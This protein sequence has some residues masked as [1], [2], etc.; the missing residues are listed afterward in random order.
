MKE[1]LD[2]LTRITPRQFILATMIIC[3]L[4]LQ[5]FFF[6]K[7]IIQPKKRN[8][9]IITKSP[10]RLIARWDKSD[11]ENKIKGDTTGDIIR[12]LDTIHK[13]EYVNY[14][15]NDSLTV[16]LGVTDAK[17]DTS[18]SHLKEETSIKAS[19]PALPGGQ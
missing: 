8:F 15:F 7:A 19:I 17:T 13:E 16:N 3:F 18:L 10:L 1:T 6:Y 2:P 5:G 9:I 4:A 11:F 12:L 14:K